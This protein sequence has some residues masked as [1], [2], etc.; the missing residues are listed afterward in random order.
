MEKIYVNSDFFV[1]FV[2][3]DDVSDSM[4]TVEY[5][6]PNGT[7]GSGSAVVS[8][9]TIQCNVARV[10]NTQVGTWKFQAKV[11]RSGLTYYT[12]TITVV[13]HERFT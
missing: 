11:V 4:V 1:R 12:Q 8:G 3:D 9:N 7:A 13:I 10:Q 2:V 5:V 6:R